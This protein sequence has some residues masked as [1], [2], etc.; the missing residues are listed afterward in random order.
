MLSFQILTGARLARQRGSRQSNSLHGIFAGASAHRRGLALDDE[1]KHVSADHPL[2]DKRRTLST[3][4]LIEGSETATMFE[5][6]T[7][8]DERSDAVSRTWNFRDASAPRS[9]T[10]LVISAGLLDRFVAVASR[11]R[12]LLLHGS[13]LGERRT[14]SQ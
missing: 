9:S 1:D 10:A 12:P 4:R 11:E 6:N 7:I 5:A 8:G 14:N 2:D 3:D 13:R